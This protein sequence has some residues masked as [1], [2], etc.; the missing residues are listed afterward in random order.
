MSASLRRR[1]PCG[2]AEG[3]LLLS[4]DCRCADGARPE[5]VPLW[6]NVVV[7]TALAGLATTGHDT[8]CAQAP[9]VAPNPTDGVAAGHRSGSFSRAPLG[10]HRPVP[11][12]RSGRRPLLVWGLRSTLT[13]RTTARRGTFRERP[14][15]LWAPRST[16]RCDTLSRRPEE[17]IGCGIGPGLRGDSQLP[18]TRTSRPSPGPDRRPTKSDVHHKDACYARDIHSY[19]DRDAVLQPRNERIVNL[20]S[21]GS[22]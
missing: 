18:D 5:L 2:P 14:L 20:G 1:P 3:W 11:S 17:S 10:R 7:F 13:P 12:S 4:R 9:G 15:K 16:K 22:E 21:L 8:A 6:V 19:D